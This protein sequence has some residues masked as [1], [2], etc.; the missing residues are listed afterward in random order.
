M[1]S[2]QEA[3]GLKKEF[4]TALGHYLSPVLSAEGEKQAWLNYK[5]GEKHIHFRMR[6]DNK[7]G[8]VGIELSHTDD[9]IRQLYFEQ[10][11][12]FR[13]I[14]ED[15]VGEE[16]IW[17]PQATEE[18]GKTVS[19]IYTAL[20]GVSVFKRE[21]WPKLISFFKPRMI[22]LDEFWSRVKYAFEALR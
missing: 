17:Q 21:D 18:Q 8:A 11:A 20:Q 12:Q 7:G 4:W 19:R 3:A 9:G 5:T 15:A 14:L 22:A 1:Y 10:F 2:K 16:W 13:K 6:A